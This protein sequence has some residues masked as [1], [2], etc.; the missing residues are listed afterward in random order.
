LRNEGNE[1]RQFYENI[2]SILYS[3]KFKKSLKFSENI[4][5]LEIECEEDI[6]H[7]DL[8]EGFVGKCAK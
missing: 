7:V 8:R 4:K 2:K 3:D 6:V 1:N 5:C